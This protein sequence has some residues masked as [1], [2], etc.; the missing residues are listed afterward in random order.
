MM[1]SK[2]S[3]QSREEKPKNLFIYVGEAETFKTSLCLRIVSSNLVRHFLEGNQDGY[4]LVILDA[5]KFKNSKTIFNSFEK[6]HPRVLKKMIVYPAGCLE[7]IRLL[8]TSLLKLKSPPIQILVDGFE[9]FLRE[10]TS[11]GG[12][13]SDAGLASTLFLLN[14][15]A[16]NA[17]A[18]ANALVEKKI[19][20]SYRLSPKE[21]HAMQ[22]EDRPRHTS[23][24]SEEVETRR[25]STSSGDLLGSLNLQDIAFLAKAAP[26]AEG[27]V[28]VARDT[29][30]MEC[31]ALLQ[32]KLL[33]AEHSVID[34]ESEDKD[35]RELN[36]VFMKILM[37]AE[38]NK[39][40]PEDN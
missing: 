40:Q 34:K 39:M 32:R 10:S 11:Y 30:S 20:I 23:I 16:Q 4:S 2:T 29:S 3:F 28:K 35:V 18:P 36:E 7:D 5:V 27:I 12:L 22:D 26:F 31:V 6:E 24:G 17:M 8:L 38:A 25:P 37:D 19:V 21:G 1:I 9:G 33:V 15:Y 13:T 14:E